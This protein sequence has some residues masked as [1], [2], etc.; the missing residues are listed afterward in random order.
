M[1]QTAVRTKLKH[2]HI[3][4]LTNITKCNTYLTGCIAWIHLNT[5]S[6]SLLTKPLYQ[7]S[8]TDYIIT[9]VVKW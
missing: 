4:L 9:C 2:N 7:V 8:E 1:V 6:L 5:K 3:I